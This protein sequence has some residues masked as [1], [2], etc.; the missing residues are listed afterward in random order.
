MWVSEASV[1]RES[2]A[3]GS[4]CASGV[5]AARAVLMESKAYCRESDHSR[6]FGLP[7]RHS[8][9]GLSVRAAAG[10]NLR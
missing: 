1:A 4:G 5:A 2:S 9:R 3:R 7:F 10:R 8:V 6:T